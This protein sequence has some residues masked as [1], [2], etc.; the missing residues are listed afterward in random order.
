MI[1]LLIFPVVWI[2]AGGLGLGL[3]NPEDTPENQMSS[4]VIGSIILGP[5]MLGMVL[6]DRY[7]K[8]K[9]RSHD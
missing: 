1:W 4:A 5:F 9:D 2:F 6:G 7:R 8:E 3:T